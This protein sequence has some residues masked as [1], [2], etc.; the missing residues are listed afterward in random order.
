MMENKELCDI[1]EGI[2]NEDNEAF[3][4]L[5]NELS[6]FVYSVSYN[7]LHDTFL[8]EDCVHDTFLHIK[9]SAHRFE[10]GRSVK[11]WVFAIARNVSLTLYKS[12]KRTVSIDDDIVKNFSV[13]DF[14]DKSDTAVLV[15]EIIMT[16]KEKDREIILM[17]LNEGMKFREIAQVLDV[18]LG[19]VIWRYNYILSKIRK[20][21][22]LEGVS[23]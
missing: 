21:I 16:L 3:E 12:Q 6:K 13:D 11:S 23:I 4:T 9:N 17:H 18:P 2:K 22:D 15:R 20:K 14:S 5:Y 8:A 1:I 7:I 10:K 19:T